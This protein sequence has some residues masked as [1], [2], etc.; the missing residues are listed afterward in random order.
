MIG[1]FS[2]IG[3]YRELAHS[4]VFYRVAFAGL[5][6]LASY[7]WDRG[8]ESASTIGIGLALVSLVL[9]GLP[10]IWGALKGL[11]RRKT[12]VDELVSIAI[13]ASVSQGEFLTAA[14]V[15]FVMVLGALI[16]Q[17]T[18]DSA[19]RTIQSLID[20][21][22]DTATVLVDGEARTVSIPEVKVGDVLLVKPGERIPVDAVVRK[23]ITAVD[24]SSITGE[25][26][27]SEKAPGDDVCAGTLNQNGVIELEATKVG[28]DTTLG[29]VIR[30]VS[31]AEAHKP[32]AIRIIDR[33]ARWFTPAI[34]LCAAV[35]W[36]LT[37][38]VNQAVTVLIVGC[39]C[40]LIL[41]APTAIVAAIGRAARS[42]VLVKGGLFL[43]E[44]G[45]ADVVLFDKTGT[46]T[47]G[48][49]RVDGVVSIEGIDTNEVLA[50]AASVEANSTHPLARA[51]LK[52]AHYAKVTISRAD[53]MV[54]EIGLGV[55][56][57]VEGSLV[58]VGSAYIGGGSMNVPSTLRCHLE[59]FK[60]T[61]AT[62]LVVYQD[63]RPLGIISVADHVRPT[64]KDTVQELQSMGIK[65]I[66]VLSGDHEQSARL[67]ADG[68]GLTEIWFGMKPHEKL[69]V[70]G[71]FQAD[72]RVVIFV[73]DG[74][75]DAPALAAANVG[76]AMGAAGTDVALETADIALMKDDISKL[77]LPG[78]TQPSNASDH[79][80]EYCLRHGLQRR[81]CA[82][83]GIGALVSDHGRGRPQHRL[84]SRGAVLGE[85]GVCFGTIVEGCWAAFAAI[86]S[87]PSATGPGGSFRPVRPTDEA[88][89]PLP[90]PAP[91][92]T[93]SCSV[94]DQNHFALRQARHQ[95]GL[96]STYKQT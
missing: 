81:G 92:E 63:K 66:G 40:A 82:G 9:N 8:S 30:L 73:G 59:D 22:P 7:L 65:R 54:T 71:D 16:E 68:V 31:E 5:L 34:L 32:Q 14:F 57:Q 10:I 18:S 19:R 74:I 58:E 3:I 2:Q 44:A 42:G 60:E 12:N 72:G 52:A 51:V 93:P 75:N 6:A 77:P 55:R 13:I 45:R 46:L 90:A 36:W 50:K 95:E 83:R 87:W 28:E 69:Q 4:R 41:A 38:Q 89:S 62:P 64:A 61:G 11:I 53:E 24:E 43:E 20:L 78:T 17:L 88:L 96:D 49:P 37:G 70:I 15:G 67:V 21:S 26:I 80:V 94:G 86:P 79:Q 56:A 35:T 84:R 39:P 85:L 33:Y 1:R 25:P 23:G 91:R 29:K 76:I 47:E 27:P 48:K